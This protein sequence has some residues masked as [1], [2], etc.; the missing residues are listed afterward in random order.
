MSKRSEI[1]R[2]YNTAYIRR[3][4]RFGS[5]FVGAYVVRKNTYATRMDGC[6]ARRR[7][8]MRV[9]AHATEVEEKEGRKEQAECVREGEEERHT[10]EGG[11]ETK[12]DF[13]R[14]IASASQS[15]DTYC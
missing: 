12:M 6:S 2:I 1:S 11:T 9:C 4:V 13:L 3:Y 15:R 14:C 8:K 7:R 10:H 5:S